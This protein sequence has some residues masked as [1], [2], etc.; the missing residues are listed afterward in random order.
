MARARDHH[1]PAPPASRASAALLLSEALAF[2]S[3][4]VAL[5]SLA[6]GPQVA[7]KG[8][9]QIQSVDAVVLGL[10]QTG[11]GLCWLALLASAWSCW[12]GR[13][14]GVGALLAQPVVVAFALV[15]LLHP[16]TWISQLAAGRVLLLGLALASTVTLVRARRNRP[17]EPR[18]QLATPLLALVLAISAIAG[19]SSAS[20]PLDPTAWATS[21]GSGSA[22]DATQGVAGQDVPQHPRLAGNPWNSIHN[23]AWATDSYTRPGP[24]PAQGPVESLFTGGDCATMT[25]DSRGRLWTICNSLRSTD[26]WLIDPDTLRV[27]DREQVGERTPDLTDFSGGGY[28]VLDARDRIVYPARGGRIVTMSARGDELHVEREL[29]LSSLLLPG[30]ELTSLVPDWRSGIWFVGSRGTVGVTGSRGARIV[31]FAGE[32]IENSLAVTDRGA[33]VVTSRV[34]ALVERG[35]GGVPRVR[36]R[37]R[38]AAG[39]RQKPGQTS[40][41]SGTTPTVL[42]GGRH[43]AIADNAEPRMK[44]VVFDTRTGRP[45]CEVPV[46]APGRSATENSLIAIGGVLIAENNYGYDPPVTA[47]T[48]G[49]TTEPGVAAI[50]VDPRSGRCRLLW[51]TRAVTVPSLVSKATGAGRQILTYSKPRSRAGFDAWYFTGV[52][53]VTGRVLWKRRAGVGSA[54]NNHYAAAYLSPAG[55]L[56]VG[57]LQGLTVLRRR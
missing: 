8:L 46:F 24:D 44:V 32:D 7:G 51:E 20:L 45:T 9:A 47:T 18:L 52:D 3:P 31:R 11:L 6:V 55:D 57:T 33:L 48:G 25:F 13:R 26:L 56:F 37:T 19:G 43:V 22:P 27:I 40:R 23:D 35:T 12:R 41:A 30:E 39:S 53:L 15:E 38:Y 2:L 50:R 1:R 34:L 21:A 36:W 17:G 14:P 49:H 42:S 54:H 4:A 16:L 10:L 28:F 5:S 29:E